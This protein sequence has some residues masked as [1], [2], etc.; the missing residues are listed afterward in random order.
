MST[1]V[2]V[3]TCT[4]VRTHMVLSAPVCPFPIRKLSTYVH[5]RTYIMLCHSFLIGKGHTYVRT[6]VH[7]YVR[8]R[9]YVFVTNIKSYK[10]LYLVLVPWYHGSM[11]TMAYV[12]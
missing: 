11:N 7:M 5:V 12:Y 8:V 9:T 2:H 1:M 6:Y 4:Y 3:Y 10:V